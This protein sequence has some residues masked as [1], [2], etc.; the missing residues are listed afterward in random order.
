[1][2][3]FFEDSFS[4]SAVDPEG[5][6]FDRVSRVNCESTTSNSVRVVFDYHCQLFPL[7]AGDKVKL[8]FSYDDDATS[9]VHG[10]YITNN[11]VFKIEQHEQTLTVL[12]SAGGLLTSIKADSNR[13]SPISNGQK[14]KAVY[15]K[16][17]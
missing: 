1:M 2:K 3:I 7:K 8:S 5:K 4:V 14:I 11:V 17:K 9:E 15:S 13:F 16:V 10:D 6:R 12:M